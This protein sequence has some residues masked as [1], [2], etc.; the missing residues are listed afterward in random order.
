MLIINFVVVYIEFL[1]KS[2]CYPVARIEGPGGMKASVD[3]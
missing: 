1:V 3:P 2:Y